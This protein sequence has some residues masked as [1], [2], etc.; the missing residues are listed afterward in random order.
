MPTQEPECYHRE[1]DLAEE[2]SSFDELSRGLAAGVLSRND[3]LKLAGA[4]LLG[5]ALGIISWSKDADARRRHRRRRRRLASPPPPPPA[6]TCSSLYTVQ[7]CCFDETTTC[8]P[9]ACLCPQGSQCISAPL[10]MPPGAF[11]CAP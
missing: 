1:E 3:A 7:P 11:V 6:P 10:G 8:R 2:H 4:A 5:G 9:D